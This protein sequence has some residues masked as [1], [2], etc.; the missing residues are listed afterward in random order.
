MPCLQSS[1]T[2]HSN[3]NFKKKLKTKLLPLPRLGAQLFQEIDGKRF[4]IAWASR[5]LSDSERRYHINERVWALEKFRI[6]LLGREFV[7]FIDNSS[8]CYLQTCG[9]LSARIAR[10]DLTVQE[11]DL[12]LQYIPGTQNIRADALSRHAAIRPP[13]P[14]DRLFKVLPMSELPQEMLSDLKKIQEYQKK[15][16]N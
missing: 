4:P 12:K 1:P 5:V 6:Y 14:S 2:T 3:S 10:Y 9:L 7:I 8:V 11:Y 13:V 16:K 15:M